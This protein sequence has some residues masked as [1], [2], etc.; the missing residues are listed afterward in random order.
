MVWIGKDIIFSMFCFLETN[1]REQ[2]KYEE[3]IETSVDNTANDL[4]YEIKFENIRN[5]WNIAFIF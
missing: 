2:R 3:R 4:R 5:V 1:I